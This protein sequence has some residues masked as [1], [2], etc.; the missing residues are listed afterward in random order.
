MWEPSE[1]EAEDCLEHGKSCSF[2]ICSECVIGITG[3]NSLCRSN[4][5][6]FA[7]VG[8]EAEHLDG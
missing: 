7:G 6:E 4:T 8:V 1:R 2:G 5:E 3:G